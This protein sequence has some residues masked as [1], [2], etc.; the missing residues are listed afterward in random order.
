MRRF[1]VA[2][3]A[4]VAA[5][6]PGLGRL[7]P[8]LGWLAG[9]QG[10]WPPHPPTLVRRV[11]LDDPAGDGA[12]EEG[13][14]LADALADDGVD[15]VVVSCGD[16]AGQVAGVVVAA[17]LLDLEPV[18]AVGT[19]S[20]RDWAALTTGVR[21]GLRATRAH[22]A[23]PVDLLAAAGSPALSRAAGL[24]AQ[25][26]V[27]RTTVLLDGSSL[28]C[29]AA[30]VAERLAPGGSTWWLAG[31][32]PPNPAAARALADLDLPPLL[33]LQ[34]ALPLGG[35]LAASVLLRAVEQLGG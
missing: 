17:A 34:L 28:V 23:D 7:G 27:R 35:D 29:G 6:D 33:D 10:A 3:P 1:V 2:L 22:V 14:A 20:A 5:P 25:C 30:L 16:P 13:V 21:D 18:H 11:L 8:A 31:Q 19:T 4:R 26:A 9:A 15:L 32:A 24:L 12:L